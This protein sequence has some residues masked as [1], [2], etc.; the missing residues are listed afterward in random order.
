MYHQWISHL[1]T[2]AYGY[3]TLLNRVV[4]RVRR[5]LGWPY[6]SMSGAIKRKVKHAV[7]FVNNFEKTL[8]NEAKRAGVDGV[9]CGH[10]HQPAMHDLDGVLYCN[11]GDWVENCTAIVEHENGKLE[12]LWWHREVGKR[13]EQTPQEILASHPETVDTQEQVYQPVGAR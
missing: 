6:W 1:G 7:K 10:V 13:A 11:S 8:V 2:W 4:N 9:I 12:I 3:L 5:W